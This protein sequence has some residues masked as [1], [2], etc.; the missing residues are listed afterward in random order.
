[1][2][3]AAIAHPRLLL[4][5]D[6]PEILGIIHGVF[7]DEG[8]LVTEAPSLS[9][10]LSLLSD[11]LFHMVI[12]DLFAEY[13]T[14]PLESVRPLLEEAAPIPVGILTAWDISEPVALQAG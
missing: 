6:D 2:S 11:H 1:M 8:C 12:T 9:A 5:E 10:S 3:S 7:E 14:P 13:G 4:I